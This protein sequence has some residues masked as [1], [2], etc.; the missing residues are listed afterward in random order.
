MVK[1]VKDVIMITMVVINVT[2]LV[3]TKIS[4]FRTRERAA[5]DSLVLGGVRVCEGG[6]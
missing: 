3:I 5:S 4:R 1:V 6:A 2:K